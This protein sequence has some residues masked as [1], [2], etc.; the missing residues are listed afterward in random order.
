MVSRVTAHWTE[1]Y[2]FGE[3]R[4]WSNKKL[5]HP[6]R[7]E[8]GGERTT[9]GSGQTGRGQEDTSKPGCRQSHPHE[10][11]E[12]SRGKAQAALLSRNKIQTSLDDKTYTH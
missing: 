2:T 1:M 11:T 5:S 12:R 3:G 6:E 9:D 4:G 8:E 10:Q 7:S